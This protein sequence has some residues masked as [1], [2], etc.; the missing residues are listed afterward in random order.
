MKWK[1]YLIAILTLILLAIQPASAGAIKK[2]FLRVVLVPATVISAA[3]ELISMPTS[4]WLDRLEEAYLQDDYEGGE[5]RQIYLH[6][7]V[8]LPGF[9]NLRD[10]YIKELV[11]DAAVNHGPREAIILLQRAIGA[12]QD[13]ELG[14]ETLKLLGSFEEANVWFKFMGQRL[15]Y[16]ASIIAHYGSQ[17]VFAQG[18]LNRCI[19]ILSAHSAEMV[20]EAGGKT[21]ESITA[22]GL[23]ASFAIWSK[24]LHPI[25]KAKANAYGTFLRAGGDCLAAAAKFK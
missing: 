25:E 5:A 12:P 1:L 2:F 18:W 6:E 14:L 4:Y 8:I 9:L 17:C 3:G 11:V 7:Y 21:T 13:G 10:P 24:Q 15:R 19:D 22:L 16:Y 20:L 23:A